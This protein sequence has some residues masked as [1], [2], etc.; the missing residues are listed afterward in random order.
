MSPVFDYFL[1][2]FGSKFAELFVHYQRSYVLE[3]SFF[4][5]QREQLFDIFG[6]VL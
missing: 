3:C 4:V 1:C 5:Y 6:L 2:S